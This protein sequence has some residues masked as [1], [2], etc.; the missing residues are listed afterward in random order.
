MRSRPS[1]TV[2]I[3]AHIDLGIMRHHATSCDIVR[4]FSGGD[5]RQAGYSEDV[6]EKLEKNL[7][8]VFEGCMRV[9]RCI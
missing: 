9:K 3:I 7:M 4:Q 2:Y 1:L 8:K 6:K 5:S